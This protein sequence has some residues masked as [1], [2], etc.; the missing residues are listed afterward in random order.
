MCDYFMADNEST[1]CIN[2]NAVEIKHLRIN[3][4]ELFYTPS[5]DQIFNL[6]QLLF[7]YKILTHL[8]HN[9]GERLTY[10][11]ESFMRGKLKTQEKL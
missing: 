9:L 5:L 6:V 1:Q 10:Y 7:T 2:I 4:N 8:T 11:V 3:N